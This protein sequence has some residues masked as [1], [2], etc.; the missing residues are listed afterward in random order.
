VLGW[1][2]GDYALRD[3]V[4]ARQRLARRLVPRLALKDGLQVG[5]PAPPA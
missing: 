1:Q 2:E 4:G 3:S 5:P